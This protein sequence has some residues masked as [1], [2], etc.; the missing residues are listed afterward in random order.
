MLKRV[1]RNAHMIRSCKLANSFLNTDKINF[2]SVIKKV[3]V[4]SVNCPTSIDGIQGS[5]AINNV[6][7]DKYK[8]LYNSVPYNKQKMSV[9]K[10][11][12]DHQILYEH[13]QCQS[14]FIHVADVIDIVKSL[15]ADKHDGNKGHYSNHITNGTHRLHCYVSLLFDS[16]ISHGFVSKDLL[17]STLIPIPKNKRKSL[18]NSDNYRAI[19]LSSILGKLLDKILLVKCQETF[20]TSMYQYGFKKIT[21]N[22]SL[23][24]RCERSN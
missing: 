1:L 23:Y 6:F 20:T 21:F 3:R 7:A 11:D 14:H 8:Y 9:L 5:S 2:W 24:I 12:I 19:A 13:N 10:Q 18:N 4:R 22:K 15:K 16:M 17:L